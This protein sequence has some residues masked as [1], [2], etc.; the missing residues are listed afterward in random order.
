MYLASLRLFVLTLFLFSASSLSEIELPD[1][2]NPS[3]IY[4]SKMDEPAI[5]RAY[6]RS[7]RAQQQVVE[8]PLLAE[9][10]QNLGQKLSSKVQSG[11]FD[12]NYFFVPQNSINAF[13]MP[14]GYIG[15]HTGLC[16]NA[17][18]ESQLASVLAHEISHVTQRHISRQI[19]DQVPNSIQGGLILLGAILLG[20][21][22]GSPE[23]VE[24]GAFAAPAIMTQGQIDF[25]REM[26]IEA[27]AI[28]IKTLGLSNY[29]PYAMA[30]FFNKLSTGDDPR[31][32]AST[33]FL[34]THPTSVNRS[35]S[36]KKQARN[37]V[38]ETVEESLGFELT[39]NRIRFLNSNLP[40][41][42]L[43][44]FENKTQNLNEKNILSNKSIGELYGLA[45]ISIELDLLEKA[46]S[47]IEILIQQNSDYAHFHIAYMD[48]LIAKGQAN[49]AIAYIEERLKLSPRNI[50]LTLAYAETEL[51]YG[52]AKKSHE[53]L[54]DLFNTIPPS[55]SQIR[56]IANSANQ[57]GDFADSFSYMAEY[58]LSIGGFEQAREQL[59]VALSFE[60]LTKIQ[61]AK[62]IA[63]LNE[64]EE[65][66][67]EMN[68]QRR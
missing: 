29:D 32:A 65:Y 55:P 30:D 44:Y 5:G 6:F 21:A 56:L 57:A 16:I 39:K 52:N 48:L 61:T 20:A 38:V 22:T 12:F 59:K 31:N 60:S 54:L 35:A 64:I 49:K 4:L 25:T 50:P 28:G 7:L 15:I 24:A 53:I 9:Y 14:G 62:F 63:R 46:E 26:E 10:I 68:R 66:I 13:A 1:L 37:M 34:R 18:N 19:G 8:D 17:D 42:T 36:A 58:Y 40:E 51:N 3:D 2:G 67:D 47:T 43:D 27:D 23:L 11:D 41:K 45:L 33:E